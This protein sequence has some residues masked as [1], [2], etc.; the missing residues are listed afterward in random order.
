MNS[1]DAMR[2]DAWNQESK[3]S[4]IMQYESLHGVY[5]NFVTFR[6]FP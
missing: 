4:R 2:V 3:R 5:L 6:C 1:E